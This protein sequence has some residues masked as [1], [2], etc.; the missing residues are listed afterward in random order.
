[1]KC[2]YCRDMR[3][4]DCPECGKFVLEAMN[5]NRPICLN[6]PDGR[7]SDDMNCCQIDPHEL[8]LALS[9]D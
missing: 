7:C 9:V 4:N 8:I 3:P 1:M 2:E 5:D 6:G